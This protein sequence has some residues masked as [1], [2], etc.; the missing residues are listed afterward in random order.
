MDNTEISPQYI[1][2][3]GDSQVLT[4]FAAIEEIVASC[5]PWPWS[6]DR[7]AVVV[8]IRNS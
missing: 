6:T 1:L 8:V 3:T 4:S 2:C 5:E 7:F